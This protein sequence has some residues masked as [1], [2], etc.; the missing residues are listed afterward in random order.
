VSQLELVAAMRNDITLREHF[1]TGIDHALFQQ[2]D[3]NGD[4]VLSFTEF[5]CLIDVNVNALSQTAPLDLDVLEDSLV[6]I[7]AST[8]IPYVVPCVANLPQPPAVDPP[9][10]VLSGKSK[11]CSEPSCKK[12]SLPTS[13]FCS[14]HKRPCSRFENVSMDAPGLCR[15][16][17]HRKEHLEGRNIQTGMHVEK[18]HKET[19]LH[20]Q[21]DGIAG[22]HSSAATQR[23]SCDTPPLA[24]PLRRQT[25]DELINM[26]GGGLH[27]G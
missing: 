24:V 5:A 7:G 19:K 27:M 23:S 1:S 9:S 12:W 10:R 4:K 3:L 17:F 2:M 6:A 25:T 21:V 16:G 14:V 18:E 26:E 13:A 20:E 8:P 22:V 15:C 11:R